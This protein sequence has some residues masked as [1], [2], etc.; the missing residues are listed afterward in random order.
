MKRKRLTKRQIVELWEAGKGMCWRCEQP[1]VNEVYPDGWVLGHCEKPHW[2]GGVEV[3]PEHVKCNSDD[4]RVQTS[5]AAKSV[6][7]RAR[8]I[9][10][11]KTRKPYYPP[12][13]R[14]IPGHW[15]S[16]DDG[17]RAIWVPEQIV[18]GTT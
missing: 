6:R 9:G 3:A 12:K 7:I 10:I 8:N 18:D 5:L 14:V 11:K 16:Y 1:I 17:K 13:P 4:G 15:E 2:M